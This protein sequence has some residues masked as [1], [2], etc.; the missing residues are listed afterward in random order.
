MLTLKSRG[1][2]LNMKD[3]GSALVLADRRRGCRWRLDAAH[4]GYRATPEGYHSSNGPRVWESFQPLADGRAARE[5]GALVVTYRVP[6]GVVRFR[7]ALTDEDAR[8]TLECTSRAIDYV[9]LPGAFFPEE[10]PHEVAVPV[11]QGLLLRSGGENWQEF[12]AHAGHLNFSMA[13]GAVLQARG[14]LLVTHECPANWSAAFGHC[15]AG[16]F[17]HFEQR[18]CPV[19]GWAGAEVR[20]HCTDADVT[21]VCKRYRAR[22]RE[23][24]ELVFW[25]QKIEA[26]PIVRELFGAL[27]AFVGYNR[28]DETDYVGSARELRQAGFES[29]FYYPLRMCQYSLGFKMGGDDPIWLDDATLDALRGIPGA[30]PAPW[31]WCVEGLDDGSPAMQH[32]FVRGADGRPEPSWKIDQFQ[33]YRV[34]TPYQ[35]EHMR[36]RFQA[37][38]KAMD[39]VHYDVAAMVDGR[40]CF[41]TEHTLHDGKPLGHI[42][43]VENIRELFSLRTVG[44]R[45]VSSEGF[46]DHYA[47]WYDIGSTKL[48]PIA[49]ERPLVTPIPMTMLVFHDSCIH[50][51][52][53]VHNYNAHAGFPIVDL[54]HG[55]GRTGSGAPRLKAA[56]DALH[57]CPPNLFPFGKQYGWTNIETRESFSYRVQL[58]DPE[59]QDAIRAALPVARL[60]KR[61]GMCELVSFELLSD[62]RLVQATSFADGTRVV[63]NL[64]DRPQEVPGCDLLPPHS[65]QAQ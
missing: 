56:L 19:D 52:W 41:S 64:S 49:G 30:H 63:A 44:N 5:N 6:D 27:M 62:D 38:M 51:W 11:Y 48:M 10:G 16:P 28:S 59:V 40:A 29:V 25:Q 8:I 9:T 57:G 2:S 4:Q 61:I 46:G 47:A 3:D 60:H 53:E 32:I 15:D 55:L 34:C 31:G 22:V 65:W 21:A 26:R 1:L 39:W 42:S 24:G 50:D 58:E 13:M 20:F 12:R 36:R 14:A 35:I 43:D 45:V 23:R 54:P 7:W 37:D 17:F 18:R 33:W